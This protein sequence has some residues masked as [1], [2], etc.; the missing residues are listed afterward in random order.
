MV[1]ERSMPGS[2]ASHACVRGG[3][4]S[5]GTFFKRSPNGTEFIGSDMPPR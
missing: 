1:V 3:T 4:A 2:S 5:S